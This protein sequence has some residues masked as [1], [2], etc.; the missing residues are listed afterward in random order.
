MLKNKPVTLL[1]AAGLLIVLIVLTLVFQFVGASASFRVAGGRPGGGQSNFQPG[2]MPDGAAL[3]DDFTPP[4][5]GQL[6]SGG[7]NGFQPGTGTDGNFSGTMTG[8]NT[9]STAMKLMQLLR[10]I[11]IG[12]AILIALLGIL[13]VVGIL[14]SK[15][16][17]R[18]WAIV[19]AILSLL[20]LIPS[21]F[22]M[23]FGS[24]LIITLVKLA[25]A[26][27]ILILCFL[28]KSK[29]AAAEA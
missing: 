12:A 21:F 25:L 27:A 29:Q 9:N 23:R 11:Q 10:G 3:P 1:I 20:A 2:Q 5:G 22:Q 15:A 26:I 13:S 28:P 6:P 18:K 19:A 17:G 7:E 24:N 14:L 8:F 16:W 4:N